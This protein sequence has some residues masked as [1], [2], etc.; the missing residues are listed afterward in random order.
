LRKRLAI[1]IIY[2]EARVPAYRL[3]DPLALSDGGIVDDARLTFT[4]GRDVRGFP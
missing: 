1:D 4:V 3:P 2:D